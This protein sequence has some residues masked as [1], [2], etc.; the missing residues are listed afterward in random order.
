MPEDPYAYVVAA[1]QAPPSPDYVMG[2]EYPPLPDFVPKLVYPEFMTPEDEVLL[3]EEQ[4]LPAA[5]SP[6]ADLPGYVPESDPESDPE[7]DD[8]EDP[9]EDTID[10]PADGGNNGDDEDESSDDDEDEDVNI[11]GDKE[12]EEHPAPADSTA[13]AL[14][15]IDQAS[16]VKETEPFETDESTATPLPYLAYRV[17]ARISIRDETP[18]SLP[19]REEFITVPV[20]SPSPPASPIRPLGYQAA[21]IRLRAEA[22]ST[23][24]SLP[25]PSPIIPSHTRPDAPPLG[26]PPLHLL[27]ADHRADR[28]RK[29]MRDLERDVGYR[30]TNTWD[31]MPVDMSGAPTTD[32]KEMG[33]RMTEDRRADARTARLIEA[34]SYRQQTGGDYRDAGGRPQETGAI[35]RGTKAAKETL[36]PNDR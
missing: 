29:I 7:E 30:I 35:H 13:V 14:P 27:S 24:H 34:E 9:E 20:L 19:P 23:S 2:P 1:F 5:A 12:E 28:P 15:A 36:D 18:I 31:G 26:T 22:A 32:D 11:K 6:T 3:A 21:M 17:T 8:D 10:Y 25:L 33:Q 4:P 16:S